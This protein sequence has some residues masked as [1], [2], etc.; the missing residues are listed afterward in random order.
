MRNLIKSAMLLVLCAFSLAASSEVIVETLCFGAVGGPQLR[1]QLRTYHDTSSG[2]SFAAVKY[3]KSAGSMP[4]AV[5]SAQSVKTSDAMPFEFTRV[6]SEIVDGRVNGE[7]EMTSQGASVS[8][9]VYRTNAKKEFHFA[10]LPS[11]D[12]DPERGCK[13]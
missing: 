6:W 10:S 2:F 7:Y 5:R 9:F 12:I 11:I 4:L 8:S 3:E 1:L 13:W